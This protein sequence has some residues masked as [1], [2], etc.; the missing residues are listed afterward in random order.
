MK[1]N[2]KLLSLILCL[3]L[4]L[5]LNGFTLVNAQENVNE[6]FTGDE[7]KNISLTY[8]VSEDY[9]RKYNLKE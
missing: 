3:G 2:L 8:N 4:C 6:I 5:G 9:V 1:N 7:I